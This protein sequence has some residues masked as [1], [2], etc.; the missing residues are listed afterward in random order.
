VPQKP[1]LI[2]EQNPLTPLQ[3][4]TTPSPHGPQVG[5]GMSVSSGIPDFRSE[6][7]L[8]DQLQRFQLP[9]PEVSLQRQ[10]CV[11]L[12]LSLSSVLSLRACPRVRLSSTLI[13]SESS[14]Q[15]S[16][17]WPRNSI[18]ATFSPPPRI[19]SSGCCTTRGCCYAASLRTLIGAAL[20]RIPNP[21]LLHCAVKRDG[22]SLSG[23]IAMSSASWGVFKG[24]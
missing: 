3:G 1:Q 16:I 20:L 21:P 12:Q 4:L 23:S 2:P 7:G 22:C 19:T 14:P 24:G 17:F 18:P 5:A 11:T 10:E 6:G 8:Y 9:Y 13:S 15:R